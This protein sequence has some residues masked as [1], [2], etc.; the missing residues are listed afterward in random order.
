MLSLIAIIEVLFVIKCIVLIYA[1]EKNKSILV[2]NDQQHGH[3][4][5]VALNKGTN[6]PTD[7]FGKHHYILSFTQIKI[8]YA[9]IIFI[10]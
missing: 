8:S 1:N 4:T 6:L 7:I 9:A 10:R 3:G 2:Q 5:T